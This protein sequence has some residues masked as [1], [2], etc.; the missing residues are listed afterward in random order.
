METR[1]PFQYHLSLFCS[2]HSWRSN[3]ISRFQQSSVA[4]EK[5]VI[6]TFTRG[7]SEGPITVFSKSFFWS[8]VI[9]FQLSFNYWSRSYLRKCILI[10]KR[11]KIPL[12]DWR[13]LI[14]SL[15][16]RWNVQVSISIN[17][18]HHTAWEYY[19]QYTSDG[20]ALLHR[21]FVGMNNFF[22]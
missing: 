14:Y 15:L 21:P 8:Q 1:Q 12:E 13:Y 11:G 17:S 5:C 16:T 2:H 4:S 10:E 3:P 22:K 7:V 6:R 18:F 20:G 19:K 9:Q